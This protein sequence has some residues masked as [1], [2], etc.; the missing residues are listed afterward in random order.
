M[1][2]VKTMKR[3]RP[4]RSAGI[5]LFF[6]LVSGLL[7]FGIGGHNPDRKQK[8]KIST[9]DKFNLSGIDYTHYDK[10]KEVFTIKSGK[11]IHRKRKVGPLTIS[12]V[13]EIE[14]AN[15]LIEINLNKHYTRNLQY[16][17]KIQKADSIEDRS[18]IFP[19][20]FSDILKETIHDERLGFISRV[21]IKGFD[22]KILRMGQQQFTIAANRVTLWP[23]SQKVMFQDGFF[24]ISR[25]GEQLVARKALWENKR[26]SFFIKGTYELSDEKGTTTGRRA[27]FAIDRYGRIKK[28]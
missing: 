7:Y 28:I 1:M 23:V 20:P 22:L 26:K 13:K 12:P 11:I 5:I 9:F 8:G 18:D 14:M 21:V 2:K 27:N 25:S 15:V 17:Q 10:G 19:L 24:L 16:D 6:I 3:R 4:M